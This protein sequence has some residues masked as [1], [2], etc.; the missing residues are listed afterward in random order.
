M[1]AEACHGYSFFDKANILISKKYQLHPA[2]AT[3]HQPN[4]CTQ[5]KKGKENKETKVPL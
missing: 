3:T 5:P 2:S 4:G 1:E